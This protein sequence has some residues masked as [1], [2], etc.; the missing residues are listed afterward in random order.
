VSV[1][2][3]GL[4]VLCLAIVVV[5]TLPVA[6]ALACGGAAALPGSVPNRAYAQA[7]ECLVN[8][9]RAG[10]GLGALAH[11]RRLAR[12]AR[13]FS[14]SMVRQRFF[15][16]VSPQGSTLVT[17]ARAA[18]YSGGTLGETIGWGA[19]SLATPASIVRGWMDSPPHHAI[20][21]SGA[22]RQIG[23][24]VAQGSPAGAAQAATVTA[25]FGG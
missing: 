2:F 11:D 17:R 7:V 23:L 22:F 6:G 24:G 20:L 21:M 25:D 15:D 12:A 5:L 3:K 19:G 9:Q 10:S 18:G 13:R 16:H 14:S 1:T 8:E 4:A